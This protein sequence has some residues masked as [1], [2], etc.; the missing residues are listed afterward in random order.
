MNAYNSIT[1]IYTQSSWNDVMVMACMI[2]VMLIASFGISLTGVNS[3]RAKR[4]ALMH[5]YELS[6]SNII[7][8]LIKE[9]PFQTLAISTLVSII[10]FAYCLRVCERPLTDTIGDQPFGYLSSCIWVTVIT[11]MTVGYGDMY[12]R[13]LPGR[14][15]AFILCVWGVFITSLIVVTLTNYVTLT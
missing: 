2:R 9:S 3:N 10:I 4:V 6:F 15:M 1:R 8:T 7:K 14:I 12:P 5:G 11:M 13:T